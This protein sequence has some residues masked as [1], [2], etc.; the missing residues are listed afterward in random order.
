MINEAKTAVSVGSGLKRA[1]ESLNWKVERMTS[2]QL[3]PKASASW[4]EM[5]FPDGK[6]KRCSSTLMGKWRLGGVDI[7]A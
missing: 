3:S 4:R 7:S 1:H 5:D 6:I 2:Q